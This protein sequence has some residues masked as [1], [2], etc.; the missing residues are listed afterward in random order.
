MRRALCIGLAAALLTLLCSAHAADKST[1]QT[2]KLID[3]SR[4][5]T[6]SGAARAQ[7]SFCLAVRLDDVTYLVRYE[8]TWRWTYAPTDLVVGDPIEVKIKGND[9][10]IQKPKGGDLKT[11]I[12]RRERNTPNQ[13]PVTCAVPVSVRN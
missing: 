13:E 1:Y 12:T 7:G 5:A 8:A 6:G 10:Y 11:N 3:L 4:V 2:G 9:M